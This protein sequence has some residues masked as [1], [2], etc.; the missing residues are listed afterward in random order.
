MK[1]GYT[2]IYVPDVKSTIEFYVKAFKLKKGFIHES[3]QYAELLTG[4]T[5]L[6]FVSESLAKSNGLSY[7]SNNIKQEAPGFEIGLIS[8][9]VKQ[10][11]TH[12]I[13]HGAI[14]IQVPTEKPWGQLVSYVRDLNG[15][16]V[17]ICS[18]MA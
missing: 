15:I 4:E 18:D 10:S 3:K 12:A 2:I 9:D 5:K 7:V 11:F 1:L 16:I 8:D 6:A 14:A 17:E 13:N